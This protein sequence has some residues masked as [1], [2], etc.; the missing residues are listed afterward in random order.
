M[1]ESRLH[2]RAVNCINGYVAENKDMLILKKYREIAADL[3]ITE[4]TL[5]TYLK[6]YSI[7]MEKRRPKDED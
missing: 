4:T 5:R 2:K 7:E 6:C 3:N 1:K